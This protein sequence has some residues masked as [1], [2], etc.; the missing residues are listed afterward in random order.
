MKNP[1]IIIRL[2]I[3]IFGFF[4]F[5]SVHA[6]TVNW[7]FSGSSGY[8]YDSATTEFSN[9]QI[10]LKGA[11]SSSWYSTSWGYRKKIT[12]NN[13]AQAENLT[14]FSVLIK[15]NSSLIDYSKTQD[16]GQDIRF[17]DSDG[18]TLLSYEIE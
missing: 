3:I 11:S 2:S 6:S 13:S 17:T 9:E 14:N 10:Q 18:L 7:D 1:K 12:F 4:L 15:L 5:S 16:S 8:T